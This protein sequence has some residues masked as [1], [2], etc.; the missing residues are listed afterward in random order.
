MKKVF[1]L[2][3]VIIMLLGLA[4]GCSNTSNETTT[5]PSNSD[6][7]GT[8][9]PNDIP[10]EH[11]TIAVGMTVVDQTME[12]VKRYL[13]DEIGPAFNVDFIFSEKLVSAED[14]LT[15]MENSYSAGAD[16]VF[17][18]ITNAQ[19]AAV[20]KGEELGMYVATLASKEAESVAMN[21]FNVGIVGIS[22]PIQGEV[23]GE[24]AVDVLS[25]GEPHNII[26]VSGGAS[27]GVTSHL[28]TTISIL[29]MLQSKYNL[30]YDKPIPELA[31]LSAQTELSTGSDM[32]V[33]IYPGFVNLPTFVPDFSTL[34]QTGKYD[35]V[36]STFSSFTT[37][38]VAIEEVEKAFSMD[39]KQITVTSINEASATAFTADESGKTALTAAVVNP[40][41]IGF[42]MGFAMLYNAITGHREDICTD[43]VAPK[44]GLTPWAINS[45]D[46][47]FALSSLDLDHDTYSLNSDDIKDL[48]YT[49]NPEV[50]GELLQ[51]TLDKL[52][53][54][55]L[56]S[57]KI[58]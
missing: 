39:V 37:L 25:D 42:G 36:L 22:G 20:A 53:A 17:C 11:Y 18:T 7:T 43:G 31:E 2:L 45:P 51:D 27:M 58:N 55:Y 33:V 24:V 32:E 34:L 54:D 23:F 29:E 9:E 3:L 15:F 52:T 19:E 47:Y 13:T 4:A 10:E 30:T 5:A 57:T 6:S 26:I 16:A 41:S 48:I 8:T 40:Q 56:K 46:D 44:L 1:S 21:P 50:N 14:L 12:V 35:V 49:F 38:G 28:D